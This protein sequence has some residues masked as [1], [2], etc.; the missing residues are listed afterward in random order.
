MDSIDIFLGLL[1]EF[2]VVCLNLGKTSHVFLRKL[3]EREEVCGLGKITLTIPSI[4][5]NYLNKRNMSW[6]C[7]D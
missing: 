7:S 6:C 5:S 4:Y 3:L 2:K 1:L